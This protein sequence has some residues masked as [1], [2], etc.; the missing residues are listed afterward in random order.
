MKI[1][2]WYD[3][4]IHAAAAG[5]AV[6]GIAWCVSAWAQQPTVT[7][8][9]DENGDGTAG[10][11]TLS[12]FTGFGSTACNGSPCLAYDLTPVGAVGSMT[13]GALLLVEPECTDV[14]ALCI[15]DVIVFITVTVDD[16]KVPLLVFFSDN[17]D[18]VDAL[19]DVGIPDLGSL[20]GV[21]GCGNR[22]TAGIC[23]INEVGPEGDNGATYHP[24]DIVG[25]G[26][27]YEDPGF[28]NG[29]DVTYIIHSDTP[30]STVPEPATLALLGLGLAG[31]G[32]SRR[33]KRN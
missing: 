8:E 14:L 29:R 5:A 7:V 17:S 12:L 16:V 27:P 23:F 11:I 24:I 10:T 15:S 18:G 20:D 6:L 30:G 13:Q 32:L 3:K 9:V 21:L 31:L 1:V 2:R 33:R 19:A 25:G 28:F 26:P 22:S 4:W